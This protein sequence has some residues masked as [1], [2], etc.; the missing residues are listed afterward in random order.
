M[1]RAHRF[2][3]HLSAWTLFAVVLAS[4]P[5]PASAQNR[6]YRI[7]LVPQTG[8]TLD[9][10]TEHRIIP[11]GHANL[12]ESGD[13]LLD[14][15]DP[16]ATDNRALGLWSGDTVTILETLSNPAPSPGGVANNLY[17]FFLSRPNNT[18]DVTFISEF[19]LNSTVADHGLWAGPPNQLELIARSG[20]PA[21]GTPGLSFLRLRNDPLYDLANVG[22]YGGSLNDA[23]DLIFRAAVGDPA[24][25]IPDCGQQLLQEGL[26]RHSLFGLEL[27][28]Q[29]GDPAP[30]LAGESFTTFPSYALNGAG[31]VVLVAETSTLSLGDGLG[32]GI[33]TGLAGSLRPV[34]VRGQ[35]APGTGGSTFTGF[36]SGW[37]STSQSS[38]VTEVQGPPGPVTNSA[39]DIGFFALSGS[40]EGIWTEQA[41]TLRLLAREGDPAQGIA[42]GVFAN[43]ADSRFHLNEA[44]QIAFTAG[45]DILGAAGS[46]LW[47]GD[48][49]ALSLVAS[50]DDVAPG[51][52]PST[53]IG[54]NTLDMNLSGDV[55]FDGRSS[56]FQF[57]PGFGVWAAGT[58]GVSSVLSPGDAIE[59]APGDFGIV[60]EALLS[61]HLVS[62]NG[63]SRAMNDAGQIALFAFAR[64]L[65]GGTLMIATPIDPAAP[66]GAPI[67][68]AGPD[69]TVASSRFAILS[70]AGSTDAEGTPL[71]FS[72]SAN[73]VPLGDGPLI[74][75]RSVLALGAHTVTLTV[76]DQQGLSGTDTMTLTVIP[77][78]AP[79]V[80]DAGPDQTVSR[81][82]SVILDGTG[83][84]DPDGDP[85][86]YTW[87]QGG[88]TIATTPT[89]TVGPFAVGIQVFTLTVSDPGGASSSDSVV[90]T[91]ANAPPFAD[92]GPHQTVSDIQSVILDG[93]GSSDPEGDALT[94]I[95]Q[96]NGT[97]VATTPTATV[98][99]F[100]VGTLRFAL[101]VSDSHGASS[102]DTVIITTVA[103]APVANAGP[104]QTLGEG[105]VFSL[106]GSASFD[107]EGG[108]LTYSWSLGGTEVGTGPTAAVGPLPPGFHVASLEV[109]DLQGTSTIDTVVLAVTASGQEPIEIPGAIRVLD[110]HAS[111]Q[112]AID[113]AVDGD[114]ILVSPGVYVESLNFQGKAITLISEFGPAMSVI[115]GTVN[116]D[117][118]E[119]LNSVLQ[120]FTVRNGGGVSI[121]RASPRI[122]G[123]RILE[124][125]K[126]SGAGVYILLASPIVQDNIISGNRTTCGGG[127]GGG[128]YIRGTAS[129]QILGNVISNNV[130]LAGHGGGISLW[131]AGTP[132]IRGNRIEGNQIGGLGGAAVGGGIYMAALSDALIIENV[133]VGNIADDAGGVY[134]AV[135]GSGQGPYLVNNT[136]AGNNGAQVGVA[137]FQAKALLTNNAISGPGIGIACLAGDNTAPPILRSNNAVSATGSA[138][139]GLC[140]GALGVDGNISTDPQFVD[141]ANGD[142]R[143]QAISNL[144]DAGDNLA[145]GLLRTDAV[146]TPRIID[147]NSDGIARIDMGAFEFGTGPVANAG[148]DQTVTDLDTVVLDG[149]GSV[150]PAGGTL[151]HV[152]SLEGATLATGPAPRVG[153]FPTGTHAVTLT[154]TDTT[155]AASADIVILTVLNHAPLADTVVELP[156]NE[157]SGM[158]AGDISGFSND[159][160]LSGG[161]AF[162]A[163]TAD[164]SAFSLRLDGVNDSIDLGA[165]DVTGSGLTLAAWFNADSFPGSSSDVR[166]ISKA[167]GT[168]SNAHVFMLST[169]KVGS[170]IRLRAR[171]RVGG[172]TTTLIASS[173]NLVPGVWHHAAVTYDGAALRLYLDAVE[174][175]SMPL[176]GAVD[177]D[178]AIPVAVGA[179]PPGAGGKY[180]DGLMDDVRILQR[181]LSAAEISGI[182][183][184]GGGNQS[185]VAADDGYAV[186][187]DSVLVAVAANGVLAN[188]TDPELDPLQAV[189]VGDVANGALT[190]SVD[191]SFAYTPALNFNGIDSFTYR[192][193]DGLTQSNLATVTLTV[194]AVSDVPVAGD[195][196]YQ[197][198]PDGVLTV[199]VANGVLSNDTDP[200]LDPLQAVL[201]GDVTNGV[202]ILNADGSF[203]Y[204]PF[205]GFSGQDGFTYRASDGFNSSNLAAVTI[206]VAAVSLDP[207]TLVQLPLDE[208]G[209][210]LAGDISGMNNHGTL[211]GG[212][213]FEANTADGSAFSIRLDGVNDA[214][215]LG[216]VDVAGTGLTL[217]AR[218]NADSFPGSSNDPRLISKATGTASNAHVFMLG[219]IKVGSAVRL[220]ARVR[221]GGSTKTLIASSGNLV[222]GV[223]H[224]A[225][226][227]YD[228][229]TL[230]LYLDAVEVSSTPLSG[231]VDVAPSV[232]VAVGGQPTGAGPRYFD[233]LLDDVRIL[234]RAMSA[235]EINQITTGGS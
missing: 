47:A 99:P 202:L 207:D 82:Q 70:A 87:K 162:E 232:P 133:I 182:V 22:T 233:G 44:G 56:D 174:V 194:G 62:D 16:I 77:P 181:A 4:V 17:P 3:K 170:A 141:A 138:Y 73:G 217:A 224:H 119:G 12:T 94:Y 132:T 180:F 191:G 83:S 227:T 129:A 114:T 161:A 23:G 208:G 165:I 111:I 179:Q 9:G 127:D 204:T 113:V 121:N 126:C 39:G 78:S 8:T 228:G 40:G 176:S 48:P 156:L 24:A 142:Y 160:T 14:S 226:V 84:S 205:G 209:G 26:W 71:Y 63:E 76:T 159:G 198:Q 150:D 201:V 42:D 29:S 197:M 37:F 66:N 199:N 61:S 152:W 163:N 206:S 200:D 210:L 139:S 74:S 54:F 101:T 58:G 60:E 216:V 116:F 90:I 214:I 215:D 223:W 72:W 50:T 96:L 130:V 231:A 41:G 146:G 147:G 103:I 123:N 97:T 15:N 104:S 25:C 89:T 175:S 43:M 187:E 188:D 128:I 168:A 46:G 20:D 100:G 213:L 105:A 6:A 34:A 192:A 134:M 52:N 7:Q 45:L 120:G 85:L 117:S 51:F 124:N 109:T 112:N 107:P 234:Q 118:G 18:G 91:T 1:S 65:A 131:D 203:G 81:T 79:P 80:A 13:V 229:A 184:V 166:L 64:G 186:T 125:S 157:G 225:A 167:T 155:G 189:L 154:V 2:F 31:D 185:P 193:S 137:G 135:P 140:A 153:R 173:G 190:L 149:T 219:T 171:V 106:D 144:V 92:A 95:W 5:D 218:F 55:A 143:L 212:A 222:P 59:V 28:A 235:A 221:V 36:R 69:Q 33:W 75:T 88:I 67:A 220:R 195:N 21:P 211:S 68:E 38:N 169:I 102:G 53:F 172:S 32:D 98:G 110:D 57:S 164:G 183:N 30:G 122:V 108:V 136:I 145:P 49:D 27:F 10:T 158:I 35:A 115:E 93:T 230:R 196:G 148:P 19:G 151:I 177:T 178:P 86:T 11:T